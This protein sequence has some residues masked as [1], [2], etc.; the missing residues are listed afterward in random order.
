[1]MN[2]FNDYNLIGQR[3]GKQIINCA[4]YTK[5]INIIHPYEDTSVN[6]QKRKRSILRE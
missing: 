3:M 4:E 6:L 5:S 1:M 2:K